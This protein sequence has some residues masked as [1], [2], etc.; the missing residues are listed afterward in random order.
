MLVEAQGSARIIVRENNLK[1][2]FQIFREEIFKIFSRPD[3]TKR[4]YREKISFRFDQK[5]K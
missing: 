1:I 5:R 3:L 4:E 2:S